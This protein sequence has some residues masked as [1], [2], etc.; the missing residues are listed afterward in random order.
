M[1]KQPLISVIMAV[2]NTGAYVGEAI[3]SILNQ[4]YE[5]FECIIVNDGSTDDSLQVIQSYKDIRI[6]VIS[7][8]NKGVVFSR[9][10][11]I[12]MANG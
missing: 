2:Y 3:D 11:A 6:K 9:N 1:D 5:N 8:A 4:S 12:A 7:R 10:E